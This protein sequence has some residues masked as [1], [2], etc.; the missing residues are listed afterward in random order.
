MVEVADAEPHVPA[1]VY[2]IVATPP[3]TPVTTPV[4]LTLAIAALLLLHVPPDIV[5]DN[6]VDAPAQTVAAPEIVPGSVLG[7]TVTGWVV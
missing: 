3:A 1:T 6:A 5:D 2:E 4:L 7:L